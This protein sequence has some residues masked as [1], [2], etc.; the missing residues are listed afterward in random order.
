MG[1]VSLS[2]LTISLN[3]IGL[4]VERVIR[5]KDEK[6]KEMRSRVQ[7]LSEENESLRRRF[8]EQQQQETALR[9]QINQ[10]FTNE[11]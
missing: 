2:K 1:A 5:Q 7:L 9:H 4:D 10:V 6:I 11:V 8:D 3:W